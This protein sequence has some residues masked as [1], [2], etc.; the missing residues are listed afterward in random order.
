MNQKT[1]LLIG[2]AFAA[3]FLFLKKPKAAKEDDRVYTELEPQGDRPQPEI[4][5]P[6]IVQTGGQV[7]TPNSPGAGSD[8]YTIGN[9]G[10][11]MQNEHFS[12]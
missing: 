5:L 7:V 4:P 3:Y 10:N 2:A 1:L 9:G 12:Y 6:Y 8:Y 11:Q